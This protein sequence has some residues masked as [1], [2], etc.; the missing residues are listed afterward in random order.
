M[1]KKLRIA[2]AQ[3]N[4]VMGDLDGNVEKIHQAW[5]QAAREKADLLVCTELCMVGYPPEDL[6]LKPSLVDD[7]MHL[8][9]K[10]VKQS[11]GN[12]TALVIG[13]P[14]REQGALYNAVILLDDGEII[15]KRFKREL[16]NYRIFDE[17]RVFAAGPLP[18]PVRWRGISLGLPVCE[19]IWLEEVPLHLAKLGA[20]MLICINGSPF[21]K[22]IAKLRHQTFDRWADKVNLPLVFVNQIGGQDELVFDGASFSKSAS[23]ELVQQLPAF[24]EHLSVAEWTRNDGN[25]HC[26]D[27]ELVSLPDVQETR[28]RAMAIGLADYVNKNGFPGVV[29]GLSGGIDSAISAVLAVDALGPERVWC[30]M[31][32]SKHTSAES[33]IDAEA[34]IQVLKC[35]YDTISIEASIDA[36]TR[37]LAPIFAGREPDTTEENLQSRARAVILM[38]LSNKFGHMLLTTGNKSE[39]AVGYATLYGDMCGGFNGLKDLYKTDVFTL[40]NWRNQ[41]CPEGLLGPAGEV[42][43]QNVIHKPPSAELRDD[44]KD[45]DSLPPYEELDDMLFGLVEDEMDIA[46]L[47]ARGHSMEEVHRI[48][49]LL[50]LAEYKRRQAPPGVKLGP[51]NFGRDRRYPITNKYRDRR[52]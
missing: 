34:S 26:A 33:L 38:A 21:R 3:L 37:T 20:Q 8:V 42:I 6:V 43:P 19:D 45:E 14:W 13:T 49:H 5:Q 1:T 44:Q 41:H 4:P 47:I 9:D 24:V 17:K 7:C 29:L 52:E 16:P 12:S 35:K 40:A 25:W 2:S 27:A 28:W 11:K 51:R 39:M 36:L 50:Y 23:G 22:G 32:P 48:E 31:M 46:S 10:L 30:V 15:A 18:K